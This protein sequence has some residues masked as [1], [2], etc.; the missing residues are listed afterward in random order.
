MVYETH[1]QK[2]RK[3][4]QA[5][6]SVEQAYKQSEQQISDV[7]ADENETVEAFQSSSTVNTERLSLTDK[8]S[9]RYE[10]T[11]RTRIDKMRSELDIFDLGRLKR[12][13]HKLPLEPS[14]ATKVF[15]LAMDRLGIK[16]KRSEQRRNLEAECL[17]DLELQ[18]EQREVQRQ[19]AMERR[20]E[21]ERQRE[22][23]AEQERKAKEE[24][25]ESLRHDMANARA[26]LDRQRMERLRAQRIQE[27]I[28]S[29]LNSRL[30]NVADLEEEVLQGN[31]E[32]Q[33]R[34]ID[35]ENARIPVY[36]LKG[37][38]F[39]MLSTT[40]DFKRKGTFLYGGETY[41]MVMD[42]PSLWTETRSQAERSGNFTANSG[43]LA[44]G[45]T[46]SASYRHSVYARNQYFGGDLIYGFASVEPDSVIEIYA[47]DGGT[48]NRINKESSILNNPNAIKNL[49]SG[50]WRV[51][52]Y[53]EFLLRRYSDNGEPK[54]PDYIVTK[55][56]VIA[57]VALRHAKFFKIP[58]VNCEET[59]Y[60]AKDERA[61]KVLLSSINDQDDY[62]T[63]AKKLE[64]MEL[65]GVHLEAL[66]EDKDEVVQEK[67]MEVKELERIKRF[68]FIKNYLTSAIDDMRLDMA[69]GVKRY[70]QPA[71]IEK[72]SVMLLD[73]ESR[74]VSP[75]SAEEYLRPIENGAVYI[76]F[77]IADRVRGADSIETRI[78]SSRGDARSTQLDMDDAM[79]FREFE[80]LA[81]QYLEIEKKWEAA[82]RQ[83]LLAS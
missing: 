19:A 38:P 60:Q 6:D 51:G 28:E 8:I 1:E 76:F 73:E 67:A 36:D 77:E 70:N 44:R 63:I 22:I 13:A 49:E 14:L 83:G 7:V 18:A 57:A 42:D 40:I 32:V 53:N 59:I 27:M 9:N 80:P 10:L 66:L 23:R 47:K 75:A 15:R 64:K 48:P 82:C 34:W 68:E 33:K 30:L 46:I 54:K 29:D 74:V 12:E 5:I 37:L 4:A 62:I 65:L 16:L 35:F 45:D 39:S 20:A 81:R 26:V 55:N 52:S 43:Q 72:F 21:L 17:L 79:L 2:Q 50:Y 69:S 56:G 11:R 3:V 31:P 78:Y 58:I 61:G 25:E 24:A 71:D 41:R